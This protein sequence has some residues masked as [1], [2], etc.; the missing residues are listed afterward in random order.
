[1]IR[2]LTNC[3]QPPLPPETRILEPCQVSVLC[4]TGRG[5]SEYKKKNQTSANTLT[6]GA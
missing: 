5:G 3:P 2:T 4:E 1:M 6:W